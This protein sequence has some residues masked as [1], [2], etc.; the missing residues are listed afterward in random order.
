MLDEKSPIW[1]AAD[2]VPIY[3][4]GEIEEDGPVFQPGC[5]DCDHTVKPMAV[6]KRYVTYVM[7]HGTGYD[8]QPGIS[9]TISTDD[10]FW[11]NI[12]ESHFLKST[13]TTPGRV[14]RPLISS[15]LAM[16]SLNPYVRLYY[17]NGEVIHTNARYS[18]ATWLKSLNKDAG[19]IRINLSCD[20]LSNFYGIYYL[21]RLKHLTKPNVNWAQLRDYVRIDPQAFPELRG[22]VSQ[23]QWNYKLDGDFP[24][25]TETLLPNTE[26]MTRVQR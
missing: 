1:E 20:K 17:D 25:S 11:S 10:A 23:L 8:G 3:T 7:T 18:V 15:L 21:P 24:F 5:F 13:L 2:L 6:E 26:P 4:R 12:D 19:G 9:F 16:P 22:L 14:Y